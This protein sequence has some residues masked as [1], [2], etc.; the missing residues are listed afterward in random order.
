MKV[1]HFNGNATRD[2]TRAKSKAKNGI[3]D[4]IANSKKVLLSSFVTGY[5]MQQMAP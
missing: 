2:S 5:Y 4:I 3:I 1:Q